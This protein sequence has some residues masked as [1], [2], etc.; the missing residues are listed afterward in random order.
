M[1][2]R[3]FI[4]LVGGGAIAWPL[5][6]R[7]QRPAMPLIGYLHSGSFEAF[8]HVVPAFREGLKGTGYVEGQ[9]VAIEYRWADSHSTDNRSGPINPTQS[10]RTAPRSPSR[11]QA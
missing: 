11:L 3:G 1:R 6:V 2:R 9:N 10:R 4:V 8:A 5:A 7:A